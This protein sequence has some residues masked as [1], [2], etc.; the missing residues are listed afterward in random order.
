MTRNLFGIN[1]KSDTCKKKKNL[2][3]EKP[4]VDFSEPLW[5]LDRLT[6]HSFVPELCVN[7]SFWKKGHQQA[8]AAGA[9]TVCTNLTPN[10]NIGTA[11]P[12]A[13]DETRWSGPANV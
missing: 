2:K 5:C 10:A 6:L 1:I 9:E 3:Y 8:S 11:A 12:S 4:S 13:S 7:L